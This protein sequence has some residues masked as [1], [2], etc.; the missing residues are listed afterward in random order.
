VTG[1]IY[2]DE[3]NRPLKSV[4]L[5]VIVVLSVT[6]VLALFL[7]VLFGRRVVAAEEAA[8]SA[9]QASLETTQTIIDKVPFALILLDMN[10]TIRRANEAA[11]QSLGLD[12]AKLTGRNW[13]DFFPKSPDGSSDSLLPVGRPG[14]GEEVDAINADG[15]PLSILRTV[16]PVVIDGKEIYIQAFVDLSERKRL[17]SELRQAQKLEAVGQLAAGIAHEINTPAQFVGDSVTFLQGAFGD[18]R[19]L[20]EKYRNLLASLAG[21]TK[22]VKDMAKAEQDVDLAYVDKNAPEAFASALE[23]IS[24]I[25]TIVGAMKSFA[26]PDTREK[27]IADVNQ[28]LKTVLIIAHNEYKDVADTQ[29]ELADLPVVR[30]HLGD[31]NQVFLNLIVNAAHAI[32]DAIGSSGNKGLIKVRTSRHDDY[33]RIDIEDSGSGVPGDIRNRIFDPFFTTKPVGKGTGQGLAIAR[34]IIVEKHGGQLTFESEMGKGTV[35]TVILPMDGG[36]AG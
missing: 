23:G 31:I 25:S 13:R 22:A 29:T 33:V 17:E 36:V 7:S 21:D 2:V 5:V 9:L 14:N 1:C 28:A 26:H 20:L 16:I 24:R 32:S 12:P 18:Q 15:A 35:F 34:S 4:K 3:L 10:L 11:G 8:K 27:G 19:A 30:C 6:V